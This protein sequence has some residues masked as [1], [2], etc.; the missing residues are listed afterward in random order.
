MIVHPSP[1]HRIGFATQ[2]HVVVRIVRVTLLQLA[3]IVLPR[4]GMCLHLKPD[5]VET[6][7]PFGLEFAVLDSPALVVHPLPNCRIGFVAEIVIPF[8]RMLGRVTHLQVRKYLAK[9]TRRESV[10][11][12]GCACRRLELA[13]WLCRMPS[14]RARLPAAYST[15]MSVF[16]AAALR[17]PLSALGLCGPRPG[18]AAPPRGHRPLEG[19]PSPHPQGR[20]YPSS[21]LL[22]TVPARRPPPVPPVEPGPASSAVRARPR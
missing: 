22:P 8:F 7:D 14:R 9:R 17:G 20:T 18:R 4:F 2:R 16:C 13:C 15:P 10:R 5:S 11:R 6:S 21:S 12:R 19:A 1:K 3:K